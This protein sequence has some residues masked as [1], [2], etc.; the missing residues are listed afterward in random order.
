MLPPAMNE[1][2]LWTDDTLLV[3]NKPA[4]L[5]TL[6]DGYN[7]AAPHVKSVLEPQFGRLWIVHRLDRFTSG[8]LLLARS[9]A[10]HRS[11]NMQFE[12]HQIQKIYHAVIIG[13][14]E[15]ESHTVELPLRAD[16]DRRH[17]T[18]ADA[19]GG[20]PAATRLRRLQTLGEFC[21]VEAQPLTGR[22]HQIRAH[23]SAI[24]F[25]I[26]GD[27]LYGGGEPSAPLTRLALHARQLTFQHPLTAEPITIEAPYPRDFA[28]ILK[29]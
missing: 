19:C 26:L 2:I 28:A 24:G 25:P 3:I 13:Q 10:A 21:L 9:A 20:R 18:V 22:T 11:L 16:G 4:G 12:Q 5:P 15:W 8:V 29:P 27:A 17:R 6:P 1:I 14:P 23:L 7:P